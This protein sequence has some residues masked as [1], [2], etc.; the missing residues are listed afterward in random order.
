MTTAVS[1]L[2]VETL[3]LEIQDDRSQAEL[4]GGATLAASRRNSSDSNTP[5]IS[6]TAA[7]CSRRAED[8][9]EPKAKSASRADFLTCGRRRYGNP[10]YTVQVG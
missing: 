9:K 3:F 6:A 2:Y 10:A 5:F 1:G 7:Q 4:T 8:R